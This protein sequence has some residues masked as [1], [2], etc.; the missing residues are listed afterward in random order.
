MPILGGI[1][2]GSLSQSAATT[3]TL[4]GGIPASQIFFAVNGTA[5]LGTTASFQGIILGKTSVTFGT[6]SSMTGRA[7]S[8]TAVTLQQTVITLP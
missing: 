6:A 3:V 1:Y 8:Q 4:S 5:A 7:Y 2:S